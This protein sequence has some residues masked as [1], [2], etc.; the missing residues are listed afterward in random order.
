MKQVYK[1]RATRKSVYDGEVIVEGYMMKMSSGLLKKWTKRYFSIRG[2]Y[3]KYFPTKDKEVVR[4]ACDLREVVTCELQNII[5][6]PA[7]GGEKESK[8]HLILLQSEVDGKKV[9]PLT[10][11]VSEEKEAH[12][13]IKAIEQV[14][15]IV[16]EVTTIDNRTKQ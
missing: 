13:W 4:G 10:L 5:G 15:H 16:H 11:E 14:T 3:L 8:R 7:K 12:K 2:S 6:P 1:Q 9:P